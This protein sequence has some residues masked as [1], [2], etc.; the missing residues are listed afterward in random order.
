MDLAESLTP[1]QA[2]AH[3]AKKHQEAV[4]RN[5]LTID[6]I[7]QYNVFFFSLR[8]EWL[9]N[10]FVVEKKKIIM[11]KEGKEIVKKEMNPQNGLDVVNK[12]KN[13]DTIQKSATNTS[14]CAEVHRLGFMGWVLGSRGALPFWF[15]GTVVAVFGWSILR[16]PGEAGVPSGMGN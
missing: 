9:I 13:R 7:C 8:P 4:L 12:A 11:K 15:V 14:T 1:T 3:Q 16:N 2:R 6:A 5:S 10:L